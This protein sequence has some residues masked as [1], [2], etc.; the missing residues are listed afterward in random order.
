MLYSTH[1]VIVFE[2]YK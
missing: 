1:K 2:E